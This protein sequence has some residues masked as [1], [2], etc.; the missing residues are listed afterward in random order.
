MKLILLGTSGSAGMPQIGGPDGRG[1]WGK[2]DP[3]EPRNRRTR[4]SAVFQTT[5]NKYILIDT[6][7]ELRLQLTACGI[8]RI[9]ALIYTHT[10]ADH[11]SGMDDIRIL[12][13]LMGGAMP[14]YATA[15]VW[16]EL[17]HRFGYVFRPITGSFYSRPVLRDHTI[18]AGQEI[19]IEGV[20]VKTMGQDHG[21]SRTLGLRT[22]NMAYCIDLV[23]MDDAQKAALQGL[24]LL[25]I[26]CFSMSKDHPTHAGLPTVLNWVEE[27]R[28]ARTVL[29][30]MGPE[31]DYATLRAALPPGVEPGYD[32]M[33]LEV[34]G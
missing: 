9:D 34:A 27:L 7:P 6:A 30:H 15:D 25:V 24:D 8:P 11:V 4:A 1:D 18:I 33:V 3:S 23:R 32:G 28:P 10:H 2:T 13:R 12:N 16:E 29:T 14:A 17:K 20:V 26:D 31:M 21:F 5:E 22:G 19:E